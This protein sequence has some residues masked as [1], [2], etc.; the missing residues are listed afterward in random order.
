MNMT[1]KHTKAPAADK[2]NSTVKN[3]AQGTQWN[4]PRKLDIRNFA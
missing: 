1:E 2:G 3:D 4:Q